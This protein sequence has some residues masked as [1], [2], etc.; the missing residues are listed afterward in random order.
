MSEASPVADDTV[1]SPK[2][3]IRELLADPAA[4][5]AFA[6]SDAG[7]ALSKQV[8]KAFAYSRATNAVGKVAASIAAA[9]GTS[10]ALDKMSASLAAASG[11]AKA[12]APV[13]ALTETVNRATAPLKALADQAKVLARQTSATARRRVQAARRTVHRF[14][15]AVARSAQR[16]FARLTG[17]RSPPLRL[18]IPPSP[19]APR[20]SAL[21]FL[22]V[23]QLDCA[24]L[25]AAPRPGP[26]AGSTPALAA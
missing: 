10:K 25:I 22:T 3:T 24:A 15:V 20:P 9:S 19:L 18:L 6:S 21:E 5:K 17:H 11:I 12:I 13:K 7:K 1:T 23:R 16:V 8:A 26:S 4:A 14:L 2:M